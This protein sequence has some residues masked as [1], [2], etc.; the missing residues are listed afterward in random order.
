MYKRQFVA[1]AD[2]ASAV[3][4][5]PA[6]L[7]TSGRLFTI[8][9]D[10]NQGHAEPATSPA[11]RTE[12]D[13][14]GSLIAIGTPPLGLSY[15]RLT[16][17]RLTP[18]GA[19]GL[20]STHLQNLV[21][22]NAGIS[23]V[24]SVVGRVAV[25]TTLRFVHAET[26]SGLS[27][28]DTEDMLGKARD[29]PSTGKNTV[30]AD[31]GVMAM[32]GQF[33]AGVTVRNLKQPTFTTSGNETVQL[34]RQSRAGIAYV[35]LQG[36]IASAD[37][38]LEPTDG[39]IGEE[40][41]IAAG[42]EAQLWPRIFLRGGFRVNTREP[43]IAGPMG[44]EHAKVYTLGGSALTI[45]SLIIDAQVTLGSKAGDRGWGIAGRMVY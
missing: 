27:N 24:Q 23:L 40:R 26:A 20:Y 15:Y 39:S 3:Y 36:L 34:K 14:T 5:N 21:T 29:L 42:A 4:W 22:H 38:D 18:A 9:L 12:G 11:S 44:A 30:D 1:V 17:T 13:R 7:A 31:V 32:L 25:G 2:D 8:N 10:F 33:R 16:A 45:R 35:G 19:N 6:G 37:F 41:N 43:L 28:V